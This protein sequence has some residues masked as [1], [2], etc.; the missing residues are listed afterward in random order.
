MPPSSA[1]A[2]AAPTHLLRSH[3]ADVTALAFSPDNERLYSG[4]ASGRVVVTSTRTLRPI[5]AW[6]AHT[7]GIL[8]VQ[9]WGARVVTHSRDHTLNVWDRVQ[10]LPAAAAA[11][12]ALEAPAP[13]LR[14]SL[15]VNALNYCRFSLLP[16]APDLA[17]ADAD[18]EDA[19]LA[20]PNLVESSEADI[21]ALPSRARIH[22]SVGT[23][24]TR[25]LFT[26]GPHEGAATGLIMALH[27]FRASA[28][29]APSDA[30]ELRLLCAYEDGSVALRRY[31]GNE[32]ESSVEGRGWDV[33]WRCKLH[34]E[35]GA[36][37]ALFLLLEGAPQTR[38]RTRQ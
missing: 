5:A 28:S 34:G 12:S 30:G 3:A 38:T 17:D 33:V 21:W 14:Y 4:D 26:P 11:A 22:A 2:P 37:S 15:A 20:L 23:Q 13:A 24:R 9:E 25:P 1:P 8:G 16:S 36:C 19:L 29:S 27:L 32:G 10:D 18:A 7:D 31:G 6:P 35:A